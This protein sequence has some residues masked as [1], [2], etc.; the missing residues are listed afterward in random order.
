MRIRRLLL[1]GLLALFSLTVGE[2]QAQNEFVVKHLKDYWQDQNKQPWNDL[3][4]KM[5]V[6]IDPQYAQEIGADEISSTD[7]PPLKYTTG[8]QFFDLKKDAKGTYAD[9]DYLVYKDNSKPVIYQ[10]ELQKNGKAPPF[11]NGSVSKK[12][13]SN[14]SVQGP[15][16]LLNQSNA[17]FWQDWLMIAG[18]LLA[19]AALVY[20]LIFRWLFSG[21]LFKRRWAVVT[22]EH[23]TWSMSL[24]VLLA[25][26]TAIAWF[27]LGPRLETFVLIGIMGAFWLLHA[28]VWMVSGKE[29]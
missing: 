11:V 17:I 4:Y 9:V 27:K 24:L 7:N 10:I 18:V 29:A 23:F 8:W 14:D 13:V 5:A 1:I 19:S 6:R 28:I 2:V 16:I 21:L 25:V 3:S 22:A 20:L 26:A 15:P 12:S